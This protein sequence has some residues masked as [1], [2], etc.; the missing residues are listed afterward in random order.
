MKV[1]H[2]TL[3]REKGKKKRK[4]AETAKKVLECLENMKKL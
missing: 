4:D 3:M 2:K 1:E